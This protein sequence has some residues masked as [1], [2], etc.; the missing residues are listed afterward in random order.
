MKDGAF[1]VC[2][3]G[4]VELLVVFLTVGFAVSLKEAGGAQLLLTLKAHKVLRVPHLPQGCDHLHVHQRRGG[5]GASQRQL[6]SKLVE[7]VREYN[8]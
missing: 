5:K 2:T 6:R 4:R 1:A 3:L 7:T 8:V